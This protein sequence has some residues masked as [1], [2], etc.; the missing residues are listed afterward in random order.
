LA[1]DM[2]R[3]WV[4]GVVDGRLREG[5]QGQCLAARRASST[6][7]NAPGTQQRE[8]MDGT[9]SEVVANCRRRLELLRRTCGARGALPL[10][11]LVE[12]VL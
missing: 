10:L 1:M 12:P 5:P 6:A 2:V 4:S 11:L 9:P 7:S 3:S 8:P